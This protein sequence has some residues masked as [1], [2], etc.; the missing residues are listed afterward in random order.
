MSS[1]TLN[2]HL[3]QNISQMNSYYKHMEE[4]LNI[5]LKNSEWNTLRPDLLFVLYS[6][7]NIHNFFQLK[8][9]NERK[10]TGK[11]SE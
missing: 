2:K 3:P 9:K 5:K 1:W 10:T 4:N 8:R 7:L 11:I 6:S